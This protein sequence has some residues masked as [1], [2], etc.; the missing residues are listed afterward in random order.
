MK[1][2]YFF[3]VVSGE[4]IIERELTFQQIYLATM[5]DKY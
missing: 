1:I 2:I 5:L 3:T 4:G